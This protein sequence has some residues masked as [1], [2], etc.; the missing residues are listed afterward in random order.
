MLHFFI[1]ALLFS[2]QLFTS[3]CSIAK[4]PSWSMFY[5]IV[6][7][8]GTLQYLASL[9]FALE[10]LVCFVT[11]IIYT[12]LHFFIIALLF[13][14]QL[15]TCYYCFIAKISS[16]MVFVKWYGDAP[17]LDKMS[18]NWLSLFTQNVSISF[19]L[20]ISRNGDISIRWRLL[21]TWFVVFT[22]SY[23]GWLSV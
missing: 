17:F 13:S 14:T 1:I 2:I 12:L 9:S 16:W 11:L 8:F 21:D 10:L 20:Y 5:Y 4:I 7:N 18:P 3:Y 19:R 23:K 22:G 6:G 15:F